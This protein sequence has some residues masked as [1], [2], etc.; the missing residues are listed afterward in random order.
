MGV[1]IKMEGEAISISEAPWHHGI[2]YPTN[3]EKM[4]EYDIIF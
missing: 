3:K 4:N 2:L 1:P